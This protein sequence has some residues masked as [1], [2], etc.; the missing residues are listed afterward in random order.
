V[1]KTTHCTACTGPGASPH[2]CI[3][4]KKSKMFCESCK[5]RGLW[6]HKCQKPIWKILATE[7]G[8]KL[9]YPGA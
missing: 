5:E 8:E 2:E 1:V 3:N 9:L 7:E 4:C 6:C